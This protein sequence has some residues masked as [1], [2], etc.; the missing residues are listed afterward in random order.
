MSA[1]PAV[2]T[3]GRG[4]GMPTEAFEML[5]FGRVP[6]EDIAS[7]PAELQSHL[8]RQTFAH[9]ERRRPGQADVILTD[10][11]LELPGRSRELT[12]LEAV[13][14]DRPFL[15]DSTLAELTARGL[16][17][18]L[19]AHPIVTLTRDNRGRLKS[20]LGEATEGGRADAGARRESII[21]IH[22][23]RINDEDERHGLIEALSRIYADV[24]VATDDTDA[25]RTQLAGLANEYRTN[26]P[27][28]DSTEV[29]EASA[30][31][32]WLSDRHFT[33]LG[34]RAQQLPAAGPV[35][36]PVTGSGLG[37]LR[38]ETAQVLRR[39][40]E[41]VAVTPEIRAFL[42][43]PHALMITKASVRSR[44]HRR[45][46]LDYIAAK[47]FLP[48]GRLW[49]E[50]AIVGLF[51]PSAYTIPAFSVPYLRRKVDRGLARAGVDPASHAGRALTEVLES[52]PRDELFQID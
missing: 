48:S 6:A 41:L 21:H 23:D 19:V 44:V 34:M 7:Y 38:D 8:G 18:R 30:F 28:L 10:F 42:E 1:E 52:Y 51:T 25:M 27:P 24:A 50:L 40:G 5:L 14:D 22:L 31:L 13:N 2:G 17:P 26:P 39:G 35:P 11:Q 16:E 47:L 20:L 43:V 15:L 12:L 29:A 46:Y 3:R 36:R 45:E 49:G 4:P 9:L 37:L 32:D 33:L